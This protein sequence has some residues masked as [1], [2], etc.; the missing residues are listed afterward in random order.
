MKP[1]LQRIGGILVEPRATLRQ[2]A[3][4]FARDVTV[5]LVLRLVCGETLALARA[6]GKLS[7]G[8]A[9]MLAALL[10]TVSA[11]LP[12][13]LGI[14]AAAIAL[15]L[16]AKRSARTLDFAM[17]AWVPY[18]A[19]QVASALA[20]TALGRA[21]SPPLKTAIDLA[22]LAWALGVLAQAFFVIREKREDAG[23]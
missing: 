7:R 15:E 12:D 1:F 18:L 6:L 5:L 23:G 3:A 22:G 16:F 11:V 2:N 13:V 21:P 8:P 20:F 19:V 17:A 9:A 4:P 10:S 14:L